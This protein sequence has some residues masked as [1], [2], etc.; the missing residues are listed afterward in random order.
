MVISLLVCLPSVVTRGRRVFVYWCITLSLGVRTQ[1]MDGLAPRRT[2]WNRQRHHRMLHITAKIPSLCRHKQQGVWA[3][4]GLGFPPLKPLDSLHGDGTSSGNT[5]TIVVTA[6]GG[7][8][9]PTACRSWPLSCKGVPYQLPM[10]RNT[11][12]ARGK[13]RR[14]IVAALCVVYNIRSRRKWGCLWLMVDKP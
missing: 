6:S 13:Q 8:R 9:V 2:S 14:E 5:S 11:A 12:A 10:H 3:E 4:R 7:S 1:L